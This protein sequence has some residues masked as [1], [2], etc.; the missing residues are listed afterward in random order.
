MSIDVGELEKRSEV[1][2][3]FLGNKLNALITVENYLLNSHSAEEVSMRMLR[4][5]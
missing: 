5:I 1:L 2:R 4:H 3:R